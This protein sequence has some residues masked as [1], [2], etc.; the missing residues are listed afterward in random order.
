MFAPLDAMF[1]RTDLTSRLG[2]SAFN[3]AGNFEDAHFQK[4]S[5]EMDKSFTM[6]T[7]EKRARKSLTI[8][9]YKITGLKL[10][11]NE[12]LQKTP[13]GGGSPLAI[14]HFQL[15]TGSSRFTMS[16]ELQ[17]ELG[18]SPSRS[19]TE[20]DADAINFLLLSSAR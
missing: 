14:R 18:T 7:Y 5:A 4:M 15:S 2:N 3:H 16:A 12:H 17:L 20:P 11:W 8:R 1:L 19:L 13:G 10:S 6:R 9:T